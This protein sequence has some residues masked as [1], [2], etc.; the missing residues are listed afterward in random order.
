[1]HHTI[2]V[3]RNLTN[4]HPKPAPAWTGADQTFHLA[5]EL[6]KFS[7]DMQIMVKYNKAPLQLVPPYTVM[8]SS[9]ITASISICDVPARGSHRPCTLL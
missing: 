4:M 8:E 9:Q 3:H 5:V 7:G 6:T 1:M 2:D